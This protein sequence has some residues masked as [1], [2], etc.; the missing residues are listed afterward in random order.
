MAVIWQLSNT[1][2]ARPAA[3]LIFPAALALR[4]C[5]YVRLGPRAI[6]RYTIW[7]ANLQGLAGKFRGSGRIIG[8]SA[9]RTRSILA[10]SPYLISAFVR[11][12]RNTGRYLFPETRTA[13]RSIEGSVGGLHDEPTDGS[14]SF[15]SHLDDGARKGVAR[16][17]NIESSL[18]GW[19]IC[20]NALLRSIRVY[21]NFRG[22]TTRSCTVA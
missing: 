10:F 4:G 16:G 6:Y 20:R 5:N 17:R 18:E 12:S 14:I 11:F 7:E 13:A 15:V 1:F 22:T 9:I 3:T 2:A 8:T 21:S 19:Q